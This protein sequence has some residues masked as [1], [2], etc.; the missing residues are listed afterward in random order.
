[1]YKKPCWLLRFRL[2]R[3]MPHREFLSPVSVIARRTEILQEAKEGFMEEHE[4]RPVR[5]N[6]GSL[7]AMVYRE[8]GN[9][10]L[11]VKAT[12]GWID[13]TGCNYLQLNHL[14]HT[15]ELQ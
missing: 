2:N 1:M 3:T 6:Y 15:T 11:Y 7:P 8:R 4:V 9:I 14:I 12:R 5:G 13:I 10:H